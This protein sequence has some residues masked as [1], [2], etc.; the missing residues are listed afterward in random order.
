MSMLEI[1]GLRREF[2]GVVA[3]DDMDAEV[4]EGSITALIGPNGA[5]KTTA[6]NL[7]TGLLTPT[8]GEVRFRGRAITGLPPYS[9]ATRGIARTFQNIRIFPRMTVLENVMVGVHARTRCG[10]YAAA[11]RLPRLLQEERLIRE[12]AARHLAFAGLDGFAGVT[13]G[14]LA[15]GQQRYLEIARAL[16]AAPT[17]LLLDEPAA[18]LNSQETRKLGRLIQSIRSLGIT[19]LLVEHDMELVMTISDIVY[20][21]NNGAMIA[22]GTPADIQ[23]HPE[24][25]RAYLG[26]A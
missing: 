10:F 26:E 8:A 2:G 24:V 7:I 6:F 22:R 11:F 20:V 17:L 19:V 23:K 14:S 1:S 25:I 16:A 13:A 5:G 3:V 15:F 9:I 4:A 12:E 21:L 18:G